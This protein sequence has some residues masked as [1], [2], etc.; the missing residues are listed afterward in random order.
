[1]IKDKTI[2]TTIENWIDNPKREPSKAVVI[3]VDSDGAVI[4]QVDD[5]GEL[6][7]RDEAIGMM[8]AITLQKYGSNAWKKRVNY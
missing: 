6:L 7:S 3:V 4:S 1:M 8:K 2:R 5:D